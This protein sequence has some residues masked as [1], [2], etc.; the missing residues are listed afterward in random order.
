M[1]EE[2]SVV[3]LSVLIVGNVVGMKEFQDFNFPL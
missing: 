2:F 3:K 1:S